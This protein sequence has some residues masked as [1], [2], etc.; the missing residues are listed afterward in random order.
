MPFSQD[1]FRSLLDHTQERS[2]ERGSVAVFICARSGRRTE[3]ATVLRP[4][5]ARIEKASY[6][7][8]NAVTAVD[9][10]KTCVSKTPSFI[11]SVK[12]FPDI[13]DLEASGIY[14]KTSLTILLLHL[15][16]LLFNQM[17]PMPSHLSLKL[18]YSLKPLLITLPWT[19]PVLILLLLPP[20][21]TPCYLSQSFVMVF[22]MPSLA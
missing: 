5:L 12:I 21:T 17:A 20:L 10:N 15:S 1:I 2:E 11:E 14:S 9:F 13:T 18:N 6:K 7:L 16:L 3:S 4:L 8:N 22:S 19:I